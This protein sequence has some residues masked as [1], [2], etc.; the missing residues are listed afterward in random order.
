LT[1]ARLLEEV[2]GVIVLIGLAWGGT[3]AGLHTAGFR[4]SRAMAKLEQHFPRYTVVFP[5]SSLEHDL[6]MEKVSKTCLSEK[7]V[8]SRIWLKRCSGLFLV[9]FFNCLLVW[10]FFEGYLLRGD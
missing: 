7:E 2:V 6:K 1:L 4:K 5:F 10:A 9:A 3:V 8:A